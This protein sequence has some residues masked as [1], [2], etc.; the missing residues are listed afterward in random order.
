MEQRQ[1]IEHFADS[2]NNLMNLLQDETNLLNTHIYKELDSLQMRKVQLTK[3]YLN[4]QENLQNSPGSLA[5]LKEEERTDLKVLYKK[6]RN[7]LSE[8]MLTLRGSYDATERVVNIVIEAVKKQR[9]VSTNSEA[10]SSRPQGY[11][12]YSILKTANMALNT[13]T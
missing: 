2:M 7:V 5:C 11:A 13:Q 1:I 3:S 10:F 8:N 12:A 4:A 9:G 6:F